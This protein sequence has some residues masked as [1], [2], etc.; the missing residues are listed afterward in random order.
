MDTVDTHH[1]KQL[2][3]NIKKLQS[4]TL[5]FGFKGEVKNIKKRRAKNVV[6]LLIAKKGSS[7]VLFREN[8]SKHKIIL[9]LKQKFN[10][11]QFLIKLKLMKVLRYN[12]LMIVLM[13]VSLK[14]QHDKDDEL[15]YCKLKCIMKI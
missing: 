4:I 5:S 6:Q 14:M 7:G 10:Y 13:K 1:N 3:A 2:L 15:L 11:L 8:L 12:I 9:Q